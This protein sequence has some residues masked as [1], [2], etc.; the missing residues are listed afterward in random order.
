MLNISVIKPI[1]VVSYENRPKI[2][3]NEPQRLTLPPL[4]TNIVIIN[5]FLLGDQVTVIDENIS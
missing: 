3:R 2:S 1:C 5:S 4:I